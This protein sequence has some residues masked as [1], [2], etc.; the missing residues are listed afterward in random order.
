MFRIFYAEQDTTLYESAPTYNTGLDEVLEIGKRL[1]T[2][3]ST[4]LHARSILKFDMSEISASLAIYNKLVTNCKFILQLYTVEAKNLPS[5]YTV[6]I[7]ML[8]QDWVNGTGYLS[9]LTTNGACW[10][11][12]Q[13][14]STWISGSQQQEIGTS[15]LYISGS[16][17][18]GNYLYYSGSSAA[19]EL[20]VS[21]SFSYRT[22]DIN[23]DV[24]D[25]IRIWLSGSNG[26]TIP[27]Y[28]F[29]VQYSDADEINDNVKGYVR[30]F[31]RDTHTIYVPK[32]TMYWD[33]SAF[34]TGSLAAANLESYV[35]YTNIKPEYKDT[36]ISKI[37]IYSR[38]KYPQKSPTNLFPI[39]TVKYLPSTTY[40]AVF[41]AQTDEAI[42]PYDN[43]YNKVSCD[44][45]SNFIYIDM[46]S[47]MPERYYRLEFKIVD[48]FT[49]QY[50]SDKI[51]FKVVR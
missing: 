18:G 3:G 14:G 47:F 23:V 46:N 21:E 42:I 34:T 40:Y 17:L 39:Q 44:S 37:R 38:D 22:S 35:I 28:G 20:Q 24:T 48:G 25:Q 5:D 9:G 13:S 19:P 6:A 36:E 26:N 12:P 50:V 27:N 32:L 49:E 8:G 2:D 4:L 11:T 31:S 10:N 1:D 15:D 33:N 7:K 30:F 45:T 51:Y 41:D 16:G 43:I 29:L